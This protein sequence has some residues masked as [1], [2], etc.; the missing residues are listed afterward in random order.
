MASRRNYLTQSELEEYSNITITD[1]AEADDQISQ[2]EEIIDAYVGP[3]TKFLRAEIRG[4]AAGGGSSTI[5]LQTSQQNVYEID[6]FKLC[7]VEILAGTGA[8]QRRICTASTKAGVLTV[9]SWETT[10]DSTS[11]Y[12]IYQLGKFPRYND[13][14]LY[15]E[16]TPYTWAKA[17]PEAIKRATAAQVQFMDEMGAEYFSTN[18]SEKISERIGDYAYSNADSNAGAVGASKL[19]A[20]KAKLMLRGIKNRTGSIVA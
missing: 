5:T 14:F 7:E 12:R 19:I 10:P 3:Q 1:V 8:G 17:I 18:Q 15:T 13:A 2:A 16:S 9:V 6:Y 20:P 11:I 4:R